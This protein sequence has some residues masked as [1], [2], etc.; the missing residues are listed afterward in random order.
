QNSKKPKILG[1]VAKSHS[2]HPATV[3][4]TSSWRRSHNPTL[5]RLIADRLREE[6][7]DELENTVCESNPSVSE[8]LNNLRQSAV[9]RDYPVSFRGDVHAKS[10]TN[11][12]ILIS[13]Y[14]DR[15][16]LQDLVRQQKRA[17]AEA[18][19]LAEQN[20]RERRLRIAENL[21][22]TAE[23]AKLAAKRS[24]SLKKHQSLSSQNKRD[25]IKPS[26]AA[27]VDAMPMECVVRA[28]Q[29][30]AE[31]DELNHRERQGEVER[32]PLK[33]ANKP[34]KSHAP[35]PPARPTL[36]GSCVVQQTRPL[37]LSASATQSVYNQIRTDACFR[38]PY[39]TTL[40][41]AFDRSS[42]STRPRAAIVS[43]SLPSKSQTTKPNRRVVGGSPQRIS[44]L[45]NRGGPR[46]TLSQGPAA[47]DADARHA[48]TITT[49]EQRV[50][51]AVNT[52]PSL[53][54]R[55]DFRSE[56]ARLQARLCASRARR[57]VHLGEDVGVGVG[58]TEDAASTSSSD[59][60]SVV[61]SYVD[62]VEPLPVVNGEHLTNPPWC[63]ASTTTDEQISV[64]PRTKR[65]LA[66]AQ[67]LDQ[68]SSPSEPYKCVESELK[69][70]RPIKP[71][72]LLFSQH[73][74][75][76]FMSVCKQKQFQLARPCGDAL[77]KP[78]TQPLVP[79]RTERRH[80]LQTSVDTVSLDGEKTC[81]IDDKDD[82]LTSDMIP[83]ASSSAIS[84]T[85]DEEEDKTSD[86]ASSLPSA[87]EC[88]TSTQLESELPLTYRQR[89]IRESKLQNLIQ[90]QTNHQPQAS[91]LAPTA[92]GLSLAAEFH[93]YD[94]LAASEQH[95]NGMEMTRQ[96]SQAQTEGLSIYQLAQAGYFHNPN[97]GHAPLLPSRVE[98]IKK[99]F[100]HTAV[101]PIVFTEVVTRSHSTTI[102][103]PFKSSNDNHLPLA[104]T[105]P[106]VSSTCSSPTTVPD[107][108][109]SVATTTSLSHHI[110]INSLDHSPR[111][112]PLQLTPYGDAATA[113]THLRPP[114]TKALGH[115][116]SITPYTPSNL[117]RS[118]ALGDI[119]ELKS[120]RF[121]CILKKRACE[122][123][124]RRQEA[125]LLLKYAAKL[126]REE[127]KVEALESKAI[128]ALTRPHPHRRPLEVFSKAIKSGAN[129][130]PTPASPTVSSVSGEKS[131]Q[132]LDE[133]LRPKISTVESSP[134]KSDRQTSP[135]TADAAAQA[136]FHETVATREV[137]SSTSRSPSVLEDFDG[138][139]CASTSTP[140][141]SSSLP[142][143]GSEARAIPLSLSTSAPA[144]DL[145]SPDHS[146]SASADPSITANSQLSPQSVASPEDVSTA[147]SI[148]SA[149]RIRQGSR[150]RVCALSPP[151]VSDGT[152]GVGDDDTTASLVTCLT[153]K[154]RE[155]QA[156]LALIEEQ[157]Q[158]AHKDRLVRLE[159]TLLQHKKLCNE[160]I[161]RLSGQIRA[162]QSSSVQ[163]TRSL[164]TSAT[165]QASRAES[166]ES[167][168]RE[169]SQSSDSLGPVS[170][171]ASI[172][173]SSILH[174]SFRNLNK[175]SA[176]VIKSAMGSVRQ[177][178][179]GSSTDSGS[180]TSSKVDSIKSAIH[181]KSGKHE[182]SASLSKRVDS[183]KSTESSLKQNLRKQPTS[184]GKS[185]FCSASGGRASTRTDSV[186]VVVE[187]EDPQ[188]SE[189]SKSSDSASDR[190]DSVGLTS[191]AS[192]ATSSLRRA[193]SK[194]L[195]K[196]SA[197]SGPTATYSSDAFTD[198]S[199]QP[200]TRTQSIKATPEVQQTGSVDGNLDS[201]SP[202]RSVLSSVSGSRASF[203]ANSIK[204]A[205]A[206]HSTS[207]P[208]KDQCSDSLSGR[209][210][211]VKSVS[212]VS[213]FAH[214]SPLKSAKGRSGEVE[215]GSLASTGQKSFDRAL[216]NE[217]LSVSERSRV[218]EMDGSS[219]A[220]PSQKKTSPAES[221]KHSRCQVAS[222]SS[223]SPSDS[224]SRVS[225]KA[226]G[227]RYAVEEENARP[228]IG[229]GLSVSAA[230]SS[231][232]KSLRS[233]LD[234]QPTPVIE[235]AK[236]SSHQAASSGDSGSRASSIV[237][238]IKSS[239]ED[240]ALALSEG[241][242]E[243]VS[244]RIDSVKSA[245][246]GSSLAQPSSP[247]SAK[248]GSGEVESTGR[249]SLERAFGK[250]A[251]S[252]SERSNVSDLEGSSV[253]KPSP[254]KT[255]PVESAKHSR[256]QVASRSSASPSDSRSRVSSKA[257]GARYA[258]EEENAR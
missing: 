190:L 123:N 130:L 252:V 39:P 26:D 62:D 70:G 150:Q 106:P 48:A 6:D 203:D 236:K 47:R 128:E 71:E 25:S 182:D 69:R 77:D 100:T 50:F 153:A 231:C 232:H 194:D 97:N 174:T 256:R 165:G 49:V 59:D 64:L 89:D 18:R 172:T 175:L 78:N 243:S 228:P 14:E 83:L 16:D 227:A 139:A 129:L 65:L 238:S 198:S 164:N 192:A 116:M 213:S 173:T 5:Q 73:D 222:S 207:T 109:L 178:R 247:K 148:S 191:A 245:S 204:S 52:T 46:P 195:S 41:N 113:T 218:S 112:P 206:A 120:D 3:A 176:P 240:E 253:A 11:G 127:R 27:P 144:A 223:E 141:A 119:M 161:E 81:D 24:Q 210:D 258:V 255:S 60:V 145:P 171:A 226:D 249:K 68:L 34:P 205:I 122:L 92:L 66:N 56:Q 35:A 140:V 133:T 193:S 79:S 42:F 33:T 177:L 169:E 40:S 111:P 201:S 136:T 74:P 246:A 1:T 151:S 241:S 219:V 143:S 166:V 134:E 103:P 185:G 7:S 230:S 98:Q 8:S 152:G 217:A 187:V 51:K 63:R 135:I 146:P 159:Q 124:A 114:N 179:R 110:S 30:L 214:S 155:Q 167:V 12:K 85:L 20:E 149:S 84:G 235:A 242:R 208:V 181:N 221:A 154:L 108:V 72:G 229:E 21:A 38:Q 132:R 220:K 215:S 87:G 86:A 75:L 28:T 88:T 212:A 257:D 91:R 180:R 158:H 99:E 197:S 250:E 45:N 157:C 196:H 32:R 170:A 254:K 239:I 15:A 121:N 188:I 61:N 44:Q 211:S 237:D 248:G 9:K 225:S 76:R 31:D 53:L 55:E 162:C 95:I 13:S 90:G 57:L 199:S 104:S 96:I 156:L 184:P 19:R 29:L 107:D 244:G 93:R 101:S 234:K 160:V 183:V 202:S 118:T 80:Y 94:A 251:P 216:T 117:E 209:L 163:S 200:P 105:E 58:H 4:T 67:P 36:R 186:E 10:P 43:N 131:D 125:Q 23:A 102:V 82:I 17:R 138:A 22:A 54:D 126:D 224:R 147:S 168:V 2:D 37:T 142:K 233:D 137:A 115:E 189:K